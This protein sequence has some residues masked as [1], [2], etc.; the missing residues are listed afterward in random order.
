MLIVRGVNLFPTSIRSILHEF[1]PDVGEIYQIRPKKRSVS[2]EPPLPIMIE[3]GEGVKKEPEG[4]G[5]RIRSEIRTRLLV[6]AEIHFVPYG[7][8]PRETY[9]YKLVEY[10]E[11]DVAVG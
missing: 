7:T 9:K 5:D 4:L 6:T 2:Q 11:N 8:L 3:L 10:P 1:T